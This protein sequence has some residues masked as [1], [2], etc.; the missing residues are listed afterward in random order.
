MDSKEQD[1]QTVETNLL[2]A[3]MSEYAVTQG[4]D[5][6]ELA[7]RIGF[8]KVFLDALFM[9]ERDV[10]Q[11]QIMGYRKISGVLGIKVTETM[12]MA[13]CIGVDDLVYRPT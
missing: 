5:L 13:G 4:L 10:R 11:L 9:G 12:L 7:E 2:L 3:K 6:D 1:V 8:S